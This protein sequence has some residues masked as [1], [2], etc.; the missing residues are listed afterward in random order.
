TLHHVKI[1]NYGKSFE[2]KGSDFFTYFAVNDATK[3]EVD[4]TNGTVKFLK[5]PN[6][7]NTPFYYP[8]PALI[9]EIAKITK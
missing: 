3:T 2:F 7:T 1:T 9:D 4:R 5:N 8:M 6:A